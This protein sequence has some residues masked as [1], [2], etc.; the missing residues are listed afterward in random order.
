[1]DVGIYP[2][3]GL[4]FSQLTFALNKELKRVAYSPSY[5]AKYKHYDLTREVLADFLCSFTFDDVSQLDEDISTTLANIREWRNSFVHINRVPLDILSLI[6]TH[7]DSQRDILNANGVCRY[8]RRTFLQ[9]AALWSR[10]DL[11]KGE[12]CVRTFL[13]RAKGTAL[14]VITRCKDPVTTV[15]LLFPHTQQIRSLHVV[16]DLWAD[17]QKVSN[18]NSGPLPFLRTLEISVL[19]DFE[20]INRA[21][22]SLPL[23]GGAADLKQLIL[24]SP[25][26]P[27]L[28]L[29]VFPNLTTFKLRT[30]WAM[31][32]LHASELLDFL[33]ASP[34][35]RA[36][37]MA[38]VDRS[39]EDVAQRK[40]VVLPNVQTFSLT[41]EGCRTPYQLITYIS[42]PF[43]TRTSLIHKREFND[44]DSIEDILYM[45]PTAAS[46][47]TI[48][49]Q[50]TRS[51]V[52]AATFYTKT[53]WDPIISCTLAFRS[54]DTTLLLGFEISHADPSP[55]DD[56]LETLLGDIHSEIFSEGFRVVRDHPL[57]SDI[58]HLHI[59]DDTPAFE[60]LQSR[61]M[62]DE[63]RELFKS[64]GPLEGLTLHGC[65][66]YSYLAH[67]LADPPDF[68]E[69]GRP[70]TYPPIKELAISHPSTKT[71]LD[72]YVEAIVEFAKSQHALG[73]PFERVTVRAR[74]L[75]MEAAE[76][77]KPWVGVVDCCEERWA[78]VG[79]KY[80]VSSSTT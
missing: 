70:I 80:L 21:N 60:A 76:M 72:D 13:E 22:L 30:T 59:V 73:V 66:L 4:S 79:N 2:G 45:F 41:M 15:S 64:M 1:M 54:S 51:P 16:R 10:L 18:I 12:T 20:A 37:D 35:L 53:Y 58:K 34:M 65:D 11:S 5:V 75:P 38:I 67:F 56:E 42:C 63:V 32:K 31:E 50:Y 68:E 6:P 36:I 29:F 55:T 52:E 47:N 71:D 3:K 14:D 17:V 43:V 57:L 49:R 33:E 27:L 24:S 26:S 78:P 25:G 8:W 61:Y 77:L 28:N 9:H 19:E 23:F 39:L 62:V 7:F 48:V 74:R 46:W 44:A 69:M 40:A